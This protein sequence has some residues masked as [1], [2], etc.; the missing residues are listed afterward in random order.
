MTEADTPR[1]AVA[2][3]V[4]SLPQTQIRRMFE[5]AE[6]QVGEVANLAL[7]EPDFDSPPHV[8][9]AACEAAAAGETHYTSNFGIPPLREAI[10][11]ET[12]REHGVDLDPDGEIAVTTGA[13]QALFFAFVA[14][15]DP[16]EEVVLPTPAWPS[17]YTQAHLAEATLREVPLDPVDG[18]DLDVDAVAGAITDRTAA[19]VLASPSN[20]TGRVYDPADVRR[21]VEAAAEHDA[22]VVADEVYGRLT[23]EGEFESVASLTDYDRVLVA[24]SM[25]KTYAMTGWRVG[26]LAGPREVIATAPQLH[27]ATSTCAAS[28]SQ[29]AALAALTGPQE[30]VREMYEAF[31]A[32][33]GYVA[34]RIAGIPGLDAETP[35]G[36]F[37]FFLDVRALDGSSVEVAD[38]LLREYGVVT[39]PGIGFGDAGE[40]FLRLSFATNRS[41]LA[42]AFDRIEAMARAEL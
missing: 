34:E 22:Y 16:G 30:P 24:N 2:D 29:H 38:R 23:F 35:E 15:V 9:E 41:E 11:A 19:V 28:V 25:S 13:I 27:Q 42:D 33:R 20:P 40:G 3:R 5:L 17:Y 31:A 1:P 26:W 14:T 18:F 8:V 6:R 39:V 10:A 37:Y 4:A 7:G 36:G 32:R 21:V 12:A